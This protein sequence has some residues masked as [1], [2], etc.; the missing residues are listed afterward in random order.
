MTTTPQCSHPLKGIVNTNDDP[1]RCAICSDFVAHRREGYTLNCCGTMACS[2][3]ISSGNPDPC[4]LCNGNPYSIKALKKHAKRGRAWAQFALARRYERG[5]ALTQ[6]YE[7]SRLWY[8][9]A[10]RQN[11]PDALHN[12]GCLYKEGVV[13]GRVDLAKARDLILSAMEIDSESGKTYAESL[14][15]ITSC[16]LY[17]GVVGE[18]EGIKQALDILIPLAGTDPETT[19]ATIEAR[20]Q[21]AYALFCKG[22]FQASYGWDCS[23]VLLAAASREENAMGTLGESLSATSTYNA[24]ICCYQLDLKAQMLFW[25]RLAQKECIPVELELDT[26]ERLTGD[27]RN[28]SHRAE[29][30]GYLR[31]V[32]DCFRGQ[33]AQILPWL[34]NVLLLQ[35]RVPED[36]LESQEGRTSRGLQGLNGTEAKV[37]GGPKAIQRLIDYCCTAINRAT[38]FLQY[39]WRNYGSASDYI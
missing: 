17:D 4:V 6:S 2:K 30:E 34:Q 31:R 29:V 21:L 16:Y 1:N 18:R 32:R 13:G 25:A 33:G 38:I 27:C 14:V 23:T 36:A 20:F 22:D 12:L 7:N 26:E 37:E 39:F 8:T 35:P 28:S 10:A 19:N 15:D 5:N 24:V 3:C 11:H 9:K